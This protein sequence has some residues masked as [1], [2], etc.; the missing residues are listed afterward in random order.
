MKISQKWV[1]PATAPLWALFLSQCFDFSVVDSGENDAGTDTAKNPPD[2]DKDSNP[3]SASSDSATDTGPTIDISCIDE[4]IPAPGIGDGL[5]QAETSVETDDV[6]SS[7]G[8]AVSGDVAYYWR[9]PFTDYYIFDTSEATYNT[10]LALYSECGGTELACSQ[11]IETAQT[12]KIVRKFTSGDEIVIVVDGWSGENGTAPLDIQR[13]PCPAIDLEGQAIPHLNSTLGAA[14]NHT[15]ECGGSGFADKAFH[16]VAATGG[17]YRFTATSDVFKPSIYVE[18]G[19]VCG[20]RQLGCNAAA[21]GS[22]G[23]EVVR[24]VAAGQPLTIIVDGQNGEGTFRLNIEKI[25]NTNCPESSLVLTLGDC[26]GG[27]GL[28]ATGELL[29]DRLLAASCAPA[30]SEDAAFQP[31]DHLDM[32]YTLK[33]PSAPTN[34]AGDCEAKITANGPLVV[35]ALRDDCGGEEVGCVAAT[36]SGGAY[37]AEIRIDM[38]QT[39]RDYILVVSAAMWMDPGPYSIHLHCSMVL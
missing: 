31:V 5:V 36:E 27:G 6:S 34:G 1:I 15:G 13:V 39:K 9:A 33:V 19:P 25:S 18:D 20:S 17:L 21:K 8:G 12:S 22:L 30:V 14:D 16:W 35:Y 29:T 4:Q 32:S 11:D 23:A 10:V 3:D 38:E 28:C 24:N 7:C 2:T 37:T 26:N